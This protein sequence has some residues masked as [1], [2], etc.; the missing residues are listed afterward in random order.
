MACSISKNQVTLRLRHKNQLKEFRSALEVET[1][2]LDYDTREP[3]NGRIRMGARKVETQEKLL[4]H[5]ARV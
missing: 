3:S 4:A 1:S 5:L 2:Q